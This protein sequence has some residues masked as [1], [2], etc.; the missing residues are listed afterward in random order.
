MFI[1]F[2][3][4]FK[5]YCRE[6]LI[7]SKFNFPSLNSSNSCWNLKIRGLGAKVCVCVC[8]CVWLWHIKVKDSIQIK[9][10]NESELKMEIVLVLQLI[11][12]SQ[13]KCKTVTSWSSR[14]KEIPC[15]FKW[16]KIQEI[17]VPVCLNGRGLVFQLSCCGF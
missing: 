5:S 10:K 7:F 12:E 14:K 13:I 8:V 16:F 3:K 2:K 11:Q 4:L 15:Q 9:H 1:N 6:K 17:Q